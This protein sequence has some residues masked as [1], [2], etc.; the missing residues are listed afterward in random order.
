MFNGMGGVW[1]GRTETPST[2]RIL[3]SQGH[4]SPEKKKKECYSLGHSA[5]PPVFLLPFARFLPLHASS[6]PLSFPPSLPPQPHHTPRNSGGRIS[7]FLVRSGWLC[8]I[9]GRV[10]GRRRVI[11]FCFCRLRFAY[12]YISVICPRYTLAN[13]TSGIIVKEIKAYFRE[14]GRTC[15]YD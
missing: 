5:P 12:K 11:R 8:V 9:V 1:T 7:E 15:L 4:L 3:S 14:T 6:L 10:G 13:Y 2:F